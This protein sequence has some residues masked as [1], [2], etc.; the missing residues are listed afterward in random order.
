[1]LRRSGGAGGYTLEE[2]GED[3]DWPMKDGEHL[4]S[5]NK[6]WLW[7]SC[8]CDSP[9]TAGSLLSLT[10]PWAL[11]ELSKLSVKEDT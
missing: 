7:S 3:H 2:V 4:R 6:R 9:Q 8:G 5:R 1:M 11:R 10:V